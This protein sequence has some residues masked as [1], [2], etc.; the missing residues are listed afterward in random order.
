MY[1]IGILQVD[2]QVFTTSRSCALYDRTAWQRPFHEP[3][4][5]ACTYGGRSPRNSFL[6][7]PLCRPDSPTNQAETYTVNYSKVRLPKRDI[8]FNLSASASRLAALVFLPPVFTHS[9][10][11]CP[12]PSAL[13]LFRSAWI[14]TGMARHGSLVCHVEGKF[15]LL[16]ENTTTASIWTSLHRP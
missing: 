1:H 13:G 12:I 16:S 7:T 11:R 3:F 4:L 15:N 14:T 10:Q 6:H 5:Y 2:N 9:F 8:L